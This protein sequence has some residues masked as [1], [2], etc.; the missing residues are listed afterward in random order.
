MTSLGTSGA[1]RPYTVDDRDQ[2]AHWIAPWVGYAHTFD[3]L[4]H[5]RKFPQNECLLGADASARY[6]RLFL[7]AAVVLFRFGR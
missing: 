4:D 2:W 6:M 5:G 3:E 7:V 1:I